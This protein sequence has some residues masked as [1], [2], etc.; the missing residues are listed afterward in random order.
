MRV[1]CSQN[2]EVR[3]SI[4]LFLRLLVG[5]FSMLIQFWLHMK[6]KWLPPRWTIKK[7]YAHGSWNFVNSPCMVCTFLLSTPAI[8]LLVSFLAPLFFFQL[9]S[10]SLLVSLNLVCNYISAQINLFIMVLSTCR[11]SWDSTEQCYKI[12]AVSVPLYL[13][14]QPSFISTYYIWMDYSHTS[15]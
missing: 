13:A 8:C 11:L 3:C 9:C 4:F 14:M 1:Y 12:G 7:S 5:E 15:P 2:D 6:R 10:F